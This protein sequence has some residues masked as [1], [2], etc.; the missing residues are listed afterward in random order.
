MY[1]GSI[2]RNYDGVTFLLSSKAAEVTPL[3]V[4]KEYKGS[5]CVLTTGEYFVLM[6]DNKSYVR[7]IKT[8][9]EKDPPK[10]L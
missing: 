7:E 10:K 4:S 6:I 8:E 3:Y 1:P 2:L 5:V 9:H